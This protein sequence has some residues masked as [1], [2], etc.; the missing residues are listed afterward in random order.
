MT[1]VIW[2]WSGMSHDA[3]LAVFVKNK[4]ELK[5]LSASHS[6]RY[7]GTKNDPNIHP[8]QTTEAL[9]LYGTP[10]SAC[11]YERPLLKKTRQL[12][13][14]QYNLLSKPTPRRWLKDNTGILL[15]HTYV[16]HHHSHSA[17]GY[18]TS[19]YTD[20]AV[21][22][23]DSIGEWETM[24][25]WKGRDTKLKRV[26]NQHFPHSIGIW[27]SAMTQRIGLK[28]QE[29]EYI[30]MGMAA[31]GDSERYYQRIKDDFF[32][33]WPTVEDPRVLF[34]ENL[35]RGCRWWLPEHHGVSDYADIAAAVQ[36]IYVEL[37]E[38]LV[39]AAKH[40]T[41]SPNI[42]L[43][44][45]CALN[46]AANS[47]ARKYFTG[48][49]I[50]PNPGDAGSSVGAVLAKH[51]TWIEW[52]GAYLGTT[53]HGDYPVQKVIDALIE[54]KITAVASGA[55]EFGPRSLG[56]RSILADPRGTDVKD[57][58][59]TIKHREAFRPFAPMILEEHADE[60]FEWLHGKPG[61]VRSPY[62]QY[63]V[64][65]KNPELFPAIIH[66]D[67]TSRVQ[68][69]NQNDCPDVYSLLQQ[70]YKQTGCPM[71][72]NTSLNIRGEPLVNDRADALRWTKQYGVEVCLPEQ[73]KSSI[74][75]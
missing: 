37:F 34:K 26:F 67:G 16:D 17:A 33:H 53:I 5:L 38:I 57:R 21:L 56:H 19:N 50:M 27:Y 10:N 1:K 31:V 75:F 48:V 74:V 12:W 11:Y 13:A 9:E 39:Q 61:R 41:Q 42:I 66:Y 55:A 59:N 70:W 52:P 18:F 45:G 22:C 68:T 71:L 60:H 30:L 3:S 62:M 64:R 65:C 20:A 46:C 29:H 73:K 2:G 35:H 51:R 72:L 25:I 43:M 47:I 7:S 69:V 63:T 8:A 6:E 24:S 32:R 58:V 36:R 4:K 44:G 40:L 49:W 23:I 54:N 28:P 15:P 14:G